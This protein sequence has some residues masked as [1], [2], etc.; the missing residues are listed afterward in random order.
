MAVYLRVGGKNF[1]VDTYL[2]EHSCETA[3]VWRKGELGFPKSQGKK[4]ED[5]GFSIMVS[6]AER[7]ELCGE[8][9]DAISFLEDEDNREEI[10]ALMSYP[11]VEG[12]TLDFGIDLEDL[13]EY[14]I[15]YYTFPPNLLRLAGS[16]GL[17]L[18]IS[19]YLS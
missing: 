13:S 10:Q 1:N 7:D 3:K 19:L 14:P 9:E 15:Q 16:F 17:C 6:D 5:S 2:Q 8:I 4:N 12:G 18:E 11:G